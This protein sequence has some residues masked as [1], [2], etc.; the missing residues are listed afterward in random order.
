MD[1]AF[2]PFGA[3]LKR[4]LADP[5]QGDQ[6]GLLLIS[7]LWRKLVGSTLAR[8]SA[9]VTLREGVL[10]VRAGSDAWG[11]E[12][13][14][15]SKLLLRRL[16]EAL[17]ERR[18]HRCRVEIGE[19]PEPTVPPQAPRTPRK[20]PSEEELAEVEELVAPLADSPGLQASFRRLLLKNLRLREEDEHE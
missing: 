10:T 4:C 9:P 3:L 13:E 12:L 8:N 1:A 19:L 16:E 6:V 14:R 15:A 7:A 5:E 11:G 20:E 2:E 18:V 17:G